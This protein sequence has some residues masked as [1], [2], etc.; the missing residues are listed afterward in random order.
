MSRRIQLEVLVWEYGHG[1]AARAASGTPPL[2]PMHWHTW[3]ISHSHSVQ[4]KPRLHPDVCCLPAKSWNSTHSHCC[5]HDQHE[6]PCF[7]SPRLPQ[8]NNHYV[9]GRLMPHRTINPISL[10]VRSNPGL[11]GALVFDTS[12]C[13]SVR[14]DHDDDDDRLHSASSSSKGP[15]QRIRVIQMRQDLP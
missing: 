13:H 10:H 5:L 6:I 1:R 12:Q 7:L 14:H 11:L 3:K 9:L 4:V 15:S 8:R 2:C